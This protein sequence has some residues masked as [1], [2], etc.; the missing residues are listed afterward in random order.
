MYDTPHKLTA[1][2]C[3]PDQLHTHQG[4]AHLTPQTNKALKQGRRQG[5]LQLQQVVNVVATLQ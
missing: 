3:V 1:R 2:P 4:Y 5:E